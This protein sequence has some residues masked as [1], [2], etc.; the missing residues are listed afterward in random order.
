[1]RS[2]RLLGKSTKLAYPNHACFTYKAAEERANLHVKWTKIFQI[3]EKNPAVM[4]QMVFVCCI[5]KLST[6]LSCYFGN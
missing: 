5:S 3:K 1:M 2:E 4:F 6:V